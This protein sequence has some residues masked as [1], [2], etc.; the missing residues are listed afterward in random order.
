MLRQF[1]PLLP[2]LPLAPLLGWGLAT[3][4]A[5]APAATAPAELVQAIAQLEA[6]ADAK[7]VAQTMALYSPAFATSD[8]TNRQQFEQMLQQFWQQYA[9]LDYAVELVAWEASPGGFTAET[10]TRVDGTQTRSGRQ[11]AMQAE[12]RSRQRFEN[13]QIVF[14]EI[15][16][17]QSQLTSGANPPAVT[18]LLPAQVEPGASYSFDAIVQ[19]PLGNRSLLGAVLNEPVVPAELMTPRLL[20]VEVLDAGGLFKLGRASEQPANRWV[21]A[22]IVREDGL[23]VETRRMQVGN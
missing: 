5:A 23:T 21:S 19:E 18:V 13:G 15:L 11:L 8:G 7:D 12:V 4:V 17:E 3:P 14:Q 16:A 1:L 22:V 20:T 10:I 9:T 6:A 2:L